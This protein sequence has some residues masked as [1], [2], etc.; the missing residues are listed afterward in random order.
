MHPHV[1]GMNVIRYR[2]PEISNYKQ[3]PIYNKQILNKI[4]AQ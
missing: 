4:N 2:D 3:I 1:A